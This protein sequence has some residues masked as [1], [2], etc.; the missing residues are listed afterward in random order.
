MRAATAPLTEGLLH[1]VLAVEQAGHPAGAGAAHGSMPGHQCGTGET[2]QAGCRLATALAG[3]SAL[4]VMQIVCN[5]H[6][7]SRL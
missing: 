7:E 4:H 1:Q 3:K 2:A 6:H 5:C